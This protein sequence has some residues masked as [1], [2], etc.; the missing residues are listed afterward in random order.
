M[1]VSHQAGPPQ[2]ASRDL[3]ALL[4]HQVTVHPFLRG[5]GRPQVAALA[6][7]AERADFA[8]GTHLF[9]QGDPADRFFLVRSGLVSLEV[10]DDPHHFRTIQTIREGDAVG[11]SW[12]FEPRTWAFDAR[13]QTVVHSVCF[14]SEPLQEL[15]RDDPRFGYDLL[16][17]IAGVMAERLQATRRQVIELSK[18][19]Y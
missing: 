19:R 11:W 5:L 1:T 3:D 6:T 13:A 15:C 8:A 17:R 10:S 7:F 14:R 9:R 2:A 12:L 16:M 18:P 4:A